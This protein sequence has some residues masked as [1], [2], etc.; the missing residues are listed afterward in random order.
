MMARSNK[1]LG[2]G[3]L[4]VRLG[5]FFR[6]ALRAGG[7]SLRAFFRAGGPT[8]AAALA[9]YALLASIPLFYLML[10]LYG[11]VAGDTWSA[12]VI[13]RRQLALIAPFV[14]EILVSRA[15]RLLWAA[16]GLGW[17]SLAFILWSSWLLIGALERF[18][19]RPWRENAP[20]PSAWPERLAHLAWSTLAGVLF[21]IAF[22]AALSVAH[23]PRL[24]PPGSLWRTVAP[25]WGVCCLTGLY[26]TVFLLF[27]PVRRPLPVLFGVALALAGAAYGVS[28]LFIT[29][30]AVLPRYH[31]VYGSLSGAV[32]FL[33]WLDYHA[34]LLVWGAWFVH[35]WQ[36][37]HPPA[38]SRRR[39]ALGS[40][41]RRLPGRFKRRS[42]TMT[43]A[44]EPPAA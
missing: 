43:E 36:Q 39:F 33:L 30:V 27:L 26:G 28:A 6:P 34:C 23:L 11:A 14:D 31:L 5:R 41:W 8:Q 10:S 20:Q 40:V 17:E 22:A 12:Q 16:P 21:V 19:A 42:G 29:V 18:L 38:P 13:L 15:R 4:R 1:I 2:L 7:T 24:E 9:F 25:V 35:A 44:A 3:K 37:Q 32:L